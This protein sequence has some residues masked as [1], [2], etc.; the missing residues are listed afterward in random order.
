MT[1]TNNLRELYR[2]FNSPMESRLPLVADPFGIRIYSTKCR[3]GR[4]WCWFY[5]TLHFL[6]SRDPSQKNLHRAILRTHQLFQTQLS[7]VIPHLDLYQGYLTKKGKE[8]PVSE[9]DYFPAR[10]QITKWNADAGPFLTIMRS[11]SFSWKRTTAMGKQPTGV[12]ELQ[13]CQQIVTS[14]KTLTPGKSY[15]LAQRINDLQACQKIIDLEG[16]T[17]GP[18]PIEIFK[19]ILRG[20]VITAASSKEI[21]K[22]IAELNKMQPKIAQLHQA[23]EAVS[24]Q[25]KKKN[26]TD[27]E[28]KNSLHKLELYLE[29]NGCTLFQTND[30]DHLAWRQ[31][32]SAGA[33][34]SLN[35]DMI[36]FDE[37]IHGC[38]F[39][40]DQT[41]VY[42]LKEHPNKVAIIAH[43]KVA[44][45]LRDARLRA[46]NIFNFQPALLL[47]I[48]NDGSVAL[49]EKLRP[50]STL[51]W[52]SKGKNISSEDAPF[53]NELVAFITS[54]VKQNITPSHLSSSYF[55]LDNE[56]HI[57]VIRPV[58]NQPFNYNLIED[59]VVECAAGNLTVFQFLMTKSGLATHTIAGYYTDLVSGHITKGEKISPGDLAGIHKIG[60]GKIVT[61]AIALIKQIGML[62][63]EIYTTLRASQ[64]SENSTALNAKINRALLACRTAH[65]SAGTLWPTL[66]QDVIEKLK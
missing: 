23:L 59:F 62:K 22:W 15:P 16:I 7:K 43:N 26:E 36:T 24:R 17:K 51:K 65:K 13:L 50:L 57:K 61:R 64:K 49:M 35:G 30:A 29:D 34:L 53:A 46:G 8:Y 55:M 18:L 19:K 66:A 21:H 28:Q 9:S 41:R 32:L 48:A 52:T 12:D 47:D 25:L 1:L 39:V 4:L 3:L 54:L 63:Q 14:G 45:A 60:D 37:E 5:K 44:L 56:H 10:R 27:V 40:G 58:V 20:K 11:Q 33:R 6:N 38:K 42:T 31:S 2:A